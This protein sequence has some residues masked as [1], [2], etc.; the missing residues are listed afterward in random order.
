MRLRLA[1]LRGENPS[2]QV[3]ARCASPRS[4]VRIELWR[5][6]APIGQPVRPLEGDLKCGLQDPRIHGALAAD[7]TE[8]CVSRI[9]IGL[10]KAGM[11]ERSLSRLTAPGLKR[12]GL[13]WFGLPLIV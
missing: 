8:V 5:G 1:F 4:S 9:G 3:N 12:A 6:I 13:T 2:A 10:A 7:L 11:V